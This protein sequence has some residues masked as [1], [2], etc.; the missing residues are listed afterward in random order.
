MKRGAAFILLLIFSCI[1]IFPQAYKGKARIIG[2]VYDQEGNPIE[3]VKVT[4]FSLKANA[5]FD[6][7]TDKKGKWIASWIRDGD[8]NVDFAKIGYLPKKI[9]IHVLEYGRNPQIEVTLEKAEEMVVSE[10]VQKELEEGNKLFKEGK[11][12]EAREVYEKMLVEFPEAYIININIGNCYFEQEN[13]EKAVEYYKKV[14]ARDPDDV[15]TILSI[16]NAYT[17]M[18]DDEKA[19]EWYTKVEMEKIDDPTVLFNIGTSLYKGSKFEDAL[20]FYRK[21]VEIKEDFLDA[22]Y[23]LGLVSLTLGHYQDSLKTFESYL[24]YDSESKR[25]EQVKGFIEFLKKKIGQMALSHPEK[26]RVYSKMDG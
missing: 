10:D 20:R 16:G 3:G 4:L 22:I 25:A 23:Q 19:L 7:K 1:L 9:S 8:W 14:H 21:A 26:D 6:I 24:K 13:F 11:Y 17:N 2:Y 5:G 15:K 12:D 18:G